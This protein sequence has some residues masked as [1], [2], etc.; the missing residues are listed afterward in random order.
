[1]TSNDE[2]KLI[3]DNELM[4]DEKSGISEEG[5]QRYSER[6]GL[7][8]PM[9]L[10]VCIQFIRISHCKATNKPNNID[11]DNIIE[12]LSTNNADIDDEIDRLQKL[13]TEYLFNFYICIIDENEKRFYNLNAT[14]VDENQTWHRACLVFDKCNRSFYAFHVRDNNHK[15]QTIFPTD[16][17]HILRL[18]EDTVEVYKWPYN[19]DR[20]KSISY[21]DVS[22]DDTE[23]TST[24]PHI[25]Y[26]PGPSKIS[27]SF[28]L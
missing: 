9:N 10:L 25:N 18:F 6:P 23:N 7:A 26:D 12:I 13:A 8:G 15:C 28:L 1:M 11:L 17:T 2:N 4:D 5:D 3:D 22:M 14:S 27:R 21:Q 24:P 19:F 16:D 20:K